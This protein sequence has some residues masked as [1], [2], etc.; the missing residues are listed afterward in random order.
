MLIGH[1]TDASGDDRAAFV[2]AAALAAATGGRVV[3]IYDGDAA[4]DLSITTLEAR[5]R[6]RIAHELRRIDEREDIADAVSEALRA[7]APGLIVVGTHARHGLSAFVHP[8]ISEAIARNVD[9]PVLFVP[10]GCRGFVD[11]ESGAISLRRILIPAHTD[12][13]AVAG[14]AAARAAIARL[15]LGAPALQLLRVDDEHAIV[16]AAATDPDGSVIVMATRG[17]DGFGDVLRGSHTERV[18]RSAPCP[19][20]SAPIAR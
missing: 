11:D 18:I 10:N 7:L 12:E 1:A 17:H 6:R 5:W 9:A 16:A 19:V 20:L 2:H 13:D 4:V 3:S 14:T 8:S 15:S